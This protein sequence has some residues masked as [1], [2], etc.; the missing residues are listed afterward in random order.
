MSSTGSGLMP[1]DVPTRCWTCYGPGQ[2][3]FSVLMHRLHRL[4]PGRLSKLPVTA[5]TGQI[6]H[7]L[8]WLVCAPAAGPR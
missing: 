3:L 6:R 4:I 8:P 5:P 7:S 1:K 2:G